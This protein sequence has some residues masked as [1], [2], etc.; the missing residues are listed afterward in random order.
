[1]RF[2]DLEKPIAFHPQL[3]RIL[4]GIEEAI[5]IQQLNYWMDKTK[6]KDGFVYKTQKEF[7]KETTL[8]RRQQERIRKKFLSKNIIETKKIKANGSPTW[9]YKINY[10]ELEKILKENPNC[11]NRTN[12]NARTVQK[13]LHETANSNCTNRTKPLTENTT[14]NTTDITETGVSATNSYTQEAKKLLQYYHDEFKKYAGYSPP[15]IWNKHNKIAVSFIKQH[16]FDTMKELLDLYLESNGNYDYYRNNAWSIDI[17]L[18]NRTIAKL[19]A[20]K[21]KI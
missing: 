10:G 1:M 15:I 5:F 11:T 12:G 20:K 17:F 6:R 16:G 13:E 3:A 19:L 7:E 14:E 18:N 21:H 2:K 9:H 4:G 8:S